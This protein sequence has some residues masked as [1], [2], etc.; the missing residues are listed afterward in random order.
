MSAEHLVVWN[1]LDVPGMDACRFQRAS[2]GWTISGVAIFIAD[3]SPAKL[4]YEI[5]CYTDWSTRVATVSGWI[6]KRNMAIA[7]ERQEGADWFLN[8]AAMACASNLVDVDLGFTPATNTSAMRR[9]NLQQGQEIETTAL[10]LDTSD[11]MF[12]PLRQLY[13]RKSDSVFDYKSPLH[14]YQ[15]ELT[16]DAFGVITNYPQLWAVAKIESNLS[17]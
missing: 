7:L 2:N 16:V 1:R 14:G 13:R 8:G 9:L 15:A 12:K 11:W 5:M 3:G 4:A 6:G 17:Q 10:W